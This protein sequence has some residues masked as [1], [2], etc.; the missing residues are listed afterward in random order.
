MNFFVY[1]DQNLPL[2]QYVNTG[3]FMLT[4]KL[5]ELK[6]ILVA[7]STDFSVGVM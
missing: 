2:F 6:L 5:D 1:L 7:I 3:I 4:S